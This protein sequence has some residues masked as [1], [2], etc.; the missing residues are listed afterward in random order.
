MGLAERASATMA[1]ALLVAAEVGDDTGDAILDLF[2]NAFTEAITVTGLAGAGV[3]AFAA[4]WVLVM[5]QGAS[6]HH[7]LAFVV[8]RERDNEREHEKPSPSSNTDCEDV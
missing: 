5:L 1:E 7:D 4:I 2:R 6:A 8:E 3:M